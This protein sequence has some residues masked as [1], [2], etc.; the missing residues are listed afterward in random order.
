[1]RILPYL[2]AALILAGCG[3]PPSKQVTVPLPPVQYSDF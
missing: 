3:T 2:I 1:M